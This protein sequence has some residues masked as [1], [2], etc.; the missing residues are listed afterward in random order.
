[1]EELN[2]FTC[3]RKSVDQPMINRLRSE[4]KRR[5]NFNKLS[6]VLSLAGNET[7]LKILFLLSVER[8]LCVCDLADIT[9]MTISA[10]SHQLRKLKDRGLIKNRRDGQ[11]IFY[12][13]RDNYINRAIKGVFYQNG[14]FG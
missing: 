9:G 1:M 10:I 13:L 4:L 12:S 3:T 11:T 2:D 8:E 6:E 5:D 14:D 7:R